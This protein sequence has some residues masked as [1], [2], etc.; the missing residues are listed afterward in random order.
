MTSVGLKAQGKSIKR[1]VLTESLIQ[2]E[3]SGAGGVRLEGNVGPPSVCEQTE[4]NK[5]QASYKYEPAR[6]A[7]DRVMLLKGAVKMLQSIA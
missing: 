6:D 5:C 4:A 2:L 1:A 7:R 3:L